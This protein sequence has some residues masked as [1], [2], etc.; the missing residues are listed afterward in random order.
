MRERAMHG[1]GKGRKYPYLKRRRSIGLVRNVVLGL[2]MFAYLVRRTKMSPTAICKVLVDGFTGM[3][4]LNLHMLSVLVFR[5]IL[6]LVR[7]ENSH[8]IYQP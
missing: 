3:M 2:Y 6:F 5:T 4:E 8:P 1:I 7:M